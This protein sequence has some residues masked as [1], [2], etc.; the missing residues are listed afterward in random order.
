MAVI[1]NAGALVKQLNNLSA[2]MTL[3]ENQLMLQVRYSSL[4]CCT[5]CLLLSIRHYLRY[6]VHLEI[7]RTF[8]MCVVYISVVHSDMH[9]H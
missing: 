2:R 4:Y 7:N 3:M 8:L 5:K 1:N 9:R 6:N